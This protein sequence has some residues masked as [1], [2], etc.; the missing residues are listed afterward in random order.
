MKAVVT[1]LRSSSIYISALAFGHQ[2]KLKARARMW[3]HDVRDVT[4]PVRGSSTDYCQMMRKVCS[5]VFAPNLFHPG[6]FNYSL[7]NLKLARTSFFSR[8]STT[9][10]FC[11]RSLRVSFNTASSK[12][13]VDKLTSMCNLEI[14]QRLSIG[15]DGQGIE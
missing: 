6:Y 1:S 3:I 7:Y 13:R 15:Q 10:L 9:N 8:A 4:A 12:I 11:A 5:S 2:S 14:V